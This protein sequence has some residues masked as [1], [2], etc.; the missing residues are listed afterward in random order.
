MSPGCLRP[1]LRPAQLQSSPLPCTFLNTSQT[2]QLFCPHPWDLVEGLLPQF[3]P[4]ILQNRKH[5]QKQNNLS[6]AGKWTVLIHTHVCLTGK[7][8]LSSKPPMPMAFRSLTQTA[9]AP[10]WPPTLGLFPSNLCSKLRDSNPG[11]AN[12][13][14][15]GQHTCLMQT[16][17]VPV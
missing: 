7:L 9:S 17:P 4:H 11:L 16:Q 2:R 8:V 14:P 5:I 13:K 15:L 10:F 6:T 3:E 1:R 12:S